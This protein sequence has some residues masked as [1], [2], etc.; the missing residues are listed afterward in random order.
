MI[1]ERVQLDRAFGAISG[2]P[3]R[4]E[5]PTPV[6]HEAF[7]LRPQHWFL[8]DAFETLDV[9]PKERL[10]VNLEVASRRIRYFWYST[11]VDA[12]FAYHELFSGQENYDGGWI[13]FDGARLRVTV[14]PIEG[15]VDGT[16]YR[17]ERTTPTEE[18]SIE[19]FLDEAGNPEEVMSPMKVVSILKED[20]DVVEEITATFKQ[21]RIKKLV[22]VEYKGDYTGENPPF[23]KRTEFDFSHVVRF[24]VR[25]R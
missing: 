5:L 21:G 23:T 15:P 2:P 8:S 22:R 9:S 20:G 10:P 17:V 13:D 1:V 3:P 25:P 14:H 11:M 6:W 19:F 4:V 24:L 16:I 12:F 18:G 7:Q